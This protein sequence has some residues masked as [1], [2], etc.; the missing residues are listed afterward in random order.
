MLGRLVGVNVFVRLSAGDSVWQVRLGPWQLDLV[1]MGRA[2]NA[3]DAMRKG[4]TLTFRTGI[5]VERRL[6]LGGQ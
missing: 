5:P 4:G 3:S 6:A 1:L 2:V